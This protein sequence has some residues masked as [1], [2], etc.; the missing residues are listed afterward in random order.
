M[1]ASCWFLSLVKK[2]KTQFTKFSWATVDHLQLSL[3]PSGPETTKKSDKYL[4]GP[5][6]GTPESLEEVLKKSSQDL[7]E[8][9]SRVS[10]GRGAGGA[11]RLF[12]NFF[13]VSRAR[14][15]RDTLVNDQ[16]QESAKGAGGKGACVINCHNFFFT[17][18]RETRR[19]DHTTTEG[20]A[21]RKM[22]QFAT[23]APFT[24][25]PFR[26]F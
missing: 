9:F 20:T 14:R 18:D 4:S 16:R 5:L 21:E 23:P 1:G 3:G 22:R 26:P 11:G 7:L 2:K 6:P 24:P 13:G 25:A 8:T 15:A 19:I 10:G 12:S 17:P